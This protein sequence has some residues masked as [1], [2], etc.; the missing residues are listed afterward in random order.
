V[1]AVYA[2]WYNAAIAELARCED[3]RPDPAWIA[4]M[5]Y[6]PVTVEQA[7]EALTRLV[8]LGVLVPDGD[9]GLRQSGEKTLSPSDLPPG[10]MSEAFAHFHEDSLAL[11][12]QAVRGVRYNERHMAGAVLAIPEEKYQSV[13]ATLREIEW[14]LVQAAS[15]YKGTP[16]RVYLIGMHI[17]PVSLYTDSEPSEPPPSEE[18][19]A[20]S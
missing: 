2:S 9:G 11:A 13:L 19:P 10:P 3:F 12:Q 6:P 8:R 17:F 15:E 5:L 1:S 4:A 7:E 18:D 20:P 14:Q 16:N